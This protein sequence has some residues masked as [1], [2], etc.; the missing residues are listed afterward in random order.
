[1]P[2]K[3]KAILITGF[4][5]EST[6]LRRSQAEKCIWNLLAA[7]VKNFRSYMSISD[8]LVILQLRQVSRVLEWAASNIQLRLRQQY[9]IE[10]PPAVFIESLSSLI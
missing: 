9:S 2:Q 8:S 4:K 10:T 5:V 3:L 1:M 7:R 6:T